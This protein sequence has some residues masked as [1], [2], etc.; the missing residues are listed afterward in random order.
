VKAIKGQ[1]SNASGSGQGPACGGDLCWWVFKHRVACFI[2]LFL[3]PSYLL[4]AYTK[5]TSKY[6]EKK[7][8]GPSF[9]PD[10][11]IVGIYHL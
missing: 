1:L 3:L 11:A 6:E 4:Q 7:A 5:V 10:E 2:S 9:L 8:S